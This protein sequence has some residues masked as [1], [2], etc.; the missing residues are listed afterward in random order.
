MIAFDRHA[1]CRLTHRHCRVPG[2]QIDHHAFVRRIEMLDQDERHPNASWQSVDELPAG[3]KAAGRG[4]DSNN[5]EFRR[6]ASRAARWQSGT[7]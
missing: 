6:A 7:T 4:A 5:W 3:V 1:V 2:Q